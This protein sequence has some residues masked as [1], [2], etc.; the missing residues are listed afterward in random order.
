MF[1]KKI[2]KAEFRV[3]KFIWGKNDIVTSKEI[4]EEM[5]QKFKWK[6]TTTLTI[7][8]RLVKKHFL[9]AER[10]SRLTYYEIIVNKEAY[11]KYATRE[12][13]NQI[14]D[15]SL[16][17]LSDSLV[18]IFNVKIDDKKKVVNDIKIKCK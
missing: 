10:I 18:E 8:S 12:F 4:V 1:I 17:S 9:K 15:G 3:M 14:H 13:L 2:P 16:E 11:L 7:L 5:E 6:P